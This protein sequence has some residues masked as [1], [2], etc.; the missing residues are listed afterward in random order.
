MENTAFT[1]ALSYLPAHLADEAVRCAALYGADAE[2][3]RLRLGQHLCLTIA[4]ENVACAAL[5]RKSDLRETFLALCGHSVYAHETTIREGYI[6]AEG[7]IRAGI[8]GR[9]VLDGNRITALSEITS[10]S[11]R[12][13]HRVPHAGDEVIRILKKSRFQK[14]ALIYS[15]PGVGKTTVLREVIYNLPHLRTAVIDTRYEL[16]TEEAPSLMVDV[17]GGYPRAK[18]IEIALRTLSPELIVCDEIGNRE[19]ADAIREGVRAG[20]PLLVSAHAGSYEELREREP[21]R[22]LLE[23]GLFPLTVG[24][25]AREGNSYRYEIR[26]ANG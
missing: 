12:L 17:L 7:G 11:I 1:R 4:G 2:E 25:L 14:N 26:E 20:V 9:A 5:C 13:P 16:F 21:L 6:A 15:P 8:C 23:E 24:L 19:D 10:V 18:G 3:I 22:R